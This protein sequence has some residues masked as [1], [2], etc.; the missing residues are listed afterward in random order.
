MRLTMNFEIGNANKKIWI[1]FFHRFILNKEDE[2]FL[3][4]EYWFDIEFVER[5]NYRIL[6]ICFLKLC[7]TIQIRK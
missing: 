2:K 1:I 7:V 5:L 4:N 6:L 3:P